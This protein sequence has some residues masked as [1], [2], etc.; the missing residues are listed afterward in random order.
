M[1]FAL[2]QIQVN[3]VHSQFVEAM[4]DLFERHKGRLGHPDLQLKV[5]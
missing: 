4:R 3:E 2:T 1:V 5:L